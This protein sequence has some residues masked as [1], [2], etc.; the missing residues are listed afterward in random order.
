MNIAKVYI[1]QKN[2]WDNKNFSPAF[3]YGEEL[4]AITSLEYD[5]FTNSDTNK[6]ID[7]DIKKAC[8]MFDPKKDYLILN[9]DPIIMGLVLYLF[10][11]KHTSLRVLKWQKDESIY[12][13]ICVN[14]LS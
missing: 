6:T 4:Y 9:G 5:P 11:K 2:K 14:T 1:S 10:L 3:R 12:I 7:N 8:D 13:P